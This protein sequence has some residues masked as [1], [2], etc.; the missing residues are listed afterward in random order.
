MR[1]MRKKPRRQG[2]CHEP[3][4]KREKT[5][6]KL[7]FCLGF[8]TRNDHKSLEM[9]TKKQ[10]KN[11]LFVTHCPPKTQPSPTFWGD[12]TDADSGGKENEE[13]DREKK[14]KKGKGNNNTQGV[15]CNC[16]STFRTFRTLL[17]RNQKVNHPQKRPSTT[18]K[19]TI[20]WPQ[21]PRSKSMKGPDP[22]FFPEKKTS[23][24]QKKDRIKHKKTGKQH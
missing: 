9:T 21:N 3:L 15:N 1:R 22:P 2:F 4:E 24:T 13:V 17:F 6:G 23:P 12:V 8:P 19:L 11:W 5:A 7:R 20:K 14:E 16:K 18:T 10:F